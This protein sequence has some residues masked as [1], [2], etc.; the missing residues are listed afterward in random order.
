MDKAL[1]PHAHWYRSAESLR[2][3]LIVVV[4]TLA[5][6]T[7]LLVLAYRTTFTA[8][9]GLAHFVA[10]AAA[11]LHFAVALLLTVRVAHAAI[12]WKN[13][14]SQGKQ[15]AELK[16]LRQTIFNTTGM[17][18][19]MLLLAVGA[20]C[21]PLVMHLVVQLPELGLVFGFLLIAVVLHSAN[22]NRSARQLRNSLTA[23]EMSAQCTIVA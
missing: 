1:F 14:R 12:V 10:I 22:I 4:L 7:S 21:I 18:A 2:N 17:T 5:L 15:T 6:T 13:L 8:L 16:Q 9:L 23:A 19:L 20:A 3:L 11:V